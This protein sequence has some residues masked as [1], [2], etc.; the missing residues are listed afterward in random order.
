MLLSDKVEPSVKKSKTLN[1]LLILLIPYTEHELP[2]LMHDLI[3]TALPTCKKSKMDKALPNLA[4][5]YIL[6]E[7]PDLIKPLSE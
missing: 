2:I 7:E 6:H 4:M 3:D 1:E 5:P